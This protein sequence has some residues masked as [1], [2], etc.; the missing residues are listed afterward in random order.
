MQSRKRS[1]M[2]LFKRSGAE[3]RRRL[4][5]DMLFVGLAAP[6]LLSLASLGLKFL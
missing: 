3:A 2:D 4:G 1:T 6:V 5:V